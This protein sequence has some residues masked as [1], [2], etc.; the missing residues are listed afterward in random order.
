MFV[1]YPYLSFDDK[2]TW[3]VCHFSKQNKLPFTHI[4][5]IAIPKF[6]LI[7]FHIWGPLAIILVH[8]HNFFDNYWW[9]YE[10]CV[11]CPS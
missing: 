3:G 1:L 9:S 11:D 8:N 4:S 7:Y 6:E 2:A 10:S 5:T